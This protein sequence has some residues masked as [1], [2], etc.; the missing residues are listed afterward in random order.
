MPIIDHGYLGVDFFFLLSGYIL[1]A[2]H[3]KEFK[4]TA[5][6]RLRAYV[7]SSCGG[8]SD[9]PALPDLAV[10][11]ISMW[12]HGAAILARTYLQ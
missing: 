1:A 3:A 10:C 7:G 11:I 2:T 6:N 9:I 8:L 5:S 12:L 4:V